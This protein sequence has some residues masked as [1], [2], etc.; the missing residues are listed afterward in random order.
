MKT[1]IKYLT[2]IVVLLVGIYAATPLWFPYIFTN[3]LPSGWQ[4]EKLEISYPGISGFDIDKLHITGELQAGGLSLIA[5]D[6]RFSYRGL[7]SDIK[8]I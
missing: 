6:G 2:Y 4:L 7:K 8:S 1:I 5:T 3:L